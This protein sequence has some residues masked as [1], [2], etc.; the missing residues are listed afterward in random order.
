MFINFLSYKRITSTGIFN[1]IERHKRDRMIP[2]VK[3]IEEDDQTTH[4]I[5]INVDTTR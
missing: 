5:V 4:L 3:W 2:I 1:I